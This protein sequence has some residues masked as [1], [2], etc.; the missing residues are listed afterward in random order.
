MTGPAQQPAR[1][2]YG[3]AGIPRWVLLALPLILLGGVALGLTSG[4]VPERFAPRR[5][6]PDSLRELRVPVPRTPSLV[7][8]PNLERL[9]ERPRSHRDLTVLAMSERYHL[10]RTMAHMVY[11]AAAE[12]GLDPELGF[13]LIRVES[14]FDPRAVGQ[15]GAAGLV[16]MMPGTARALD[17]EIDTT[18]EL[19]DP[20]TNLRL[21]FRLLRENILRYQKQGDD[22]VRLGVIAYN[23]GENSVDRALRRGRDPE[24]GYGKRVLGPIHHGG[25]P[26]Q[27][28][29]LRPKE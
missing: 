18:R 15:G 25:K 19:M 10:T 9:V 26:Y 21:G 12:A 3:L 28:T 24:N 29:G 7:S 1:T 4:S 23:R 20:H 2:Q 5:G 13:R 14:V 6:V 27:G 22:A 17:P 16:Q 8:T 11:D